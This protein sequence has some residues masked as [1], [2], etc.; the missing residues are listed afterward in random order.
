MTRV[1]LRGLLGR[2]LRAVADGAR[3]RPRRRDG[4]RH[5]RP[6]R[7][8]RQG[9]Q[10][11][12]RGVVRRHRRRRHRQ[13]DRTSASRAT[14]PRRRPSRR[15]SSSR[16]AASTASR[17]RPA[18]S[19]TSR[20]AKILDRDGKAIS[21]N[22]APTFGFGLDTSPEASRFNPL[23]LLEGRWAAGAERGR[24]RRSTPPTTRT[25]A[26]ATPCK[27]ASLG[28]VQ[29][30]TV[31][32][33]AKYGDLESLG[34]GDVRRLRH[35]DGTAPLRPDERVRR[36]PGRG[37]RRRDSG[38]SSSQRI[39]AAIAADVDRRSP[40]SSRRARTATRSPSSRSS[41]S[42]S[43]SRSAASRS[44]SAPSSSST[45]C[46]S[47]SPSGRA[48]SRRCGRSAL[49]ARQVRLS[50]LLEAL[51]IGVVA[52]IVGLGLGYLLAK[53]LNA[54]FEALDLGAAA[55]RASSSRRARSSSRLIV[56]IVRDAAG[57][58]LPGAAGDAR[59]ADLGRA[60]GGDASDGALLALYAR[61]SPWSRSPARWRCSATRCSSTSV[62]TAD[63]PAL[64]RRRRAAP[65]RRRGDDL[66]AG[67]SAARVGA[68][69]DREMADGRS[70]PS[71]SIRSRWRC[72]SSRTRSSPVA[73]RPRAGI[74]AGVGRRDSSGSASARSCCR[75]CRRSSRS[76]SPAIVLAVAIF[77]I[78]RAVRAEPSRWSS[79]ACVPTAPRPRLSR[80]TRPAT[81]AARRRPPPR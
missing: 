14:R 69:A 41:S 8:D 21:G 11:D 63:A 56:G 62:D 2:K 60:R 55:D 45:R 7:H 49:R 35:P 34:H 78:V 4:E 1:A 58:A 29:S 54:L 5:V 24:D 20:S 43:C 59:A 16:S 32:G 79:R 26:S 57:R 9:V 52:S 46:R 10:P 6:H 38:R 53:G 77:L 27:I 61:T 18:A 36:D 22:G 23:N 75:A 39:D 48:S 44:S 65:L 33:I 3:D 31:V 67:R 76:S 15:A 71:C 47:P 64:D 51:I 25:T 37:R 66:A 12:L 13:G 40:A 42:T 73:R 68:L 30:F 80:R 70:S 81:P 74:A 17:S 72:G 19:S 50:V 28:P